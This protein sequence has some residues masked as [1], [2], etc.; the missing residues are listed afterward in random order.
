MVVELTESAFWQPKVSSTFHGRDVFAPVAAALA[1]S[2][3]LS[4]L[5]RP[6]DS[7]VNLAWPEVVRSTDG[8]VRGEVV[9]VD[10]YGN[11]ITNLRPSDLPPDPVFCL[12]TERAEGLAPHFQVEQR[13]LALVG[14]SGLVEIAAPNASAA[15]I[16]GEGTG[17]VVA[18]HP[19]RR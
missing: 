2:V 14:S 6:I 13:L 1:S 5:G 4:D 7:L 15:S 9:S 17:S 8:V 12:G 18:C 3:T 19:A 11:L 16:L 10:L